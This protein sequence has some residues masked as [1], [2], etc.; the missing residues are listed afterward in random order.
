MA[1]CRRHARSCLDLPRLGLIA[2]PSAMRQGGQCDVGQGQGKRWWGACARACAYPA[3]PA[4]AA[5]GPVQA[6]LLGQ[7]AG[8]PAQAADQF[9]PA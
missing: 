2:L 7:S 3:V 9:M 6:S 5:L 8:A 4:V 1:H